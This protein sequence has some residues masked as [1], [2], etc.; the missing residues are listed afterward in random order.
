M[1]NAVKVLVGLLV[2]TVV[3]AGGVTWWKKQADE[4]YDGLMPKGDAS[5][6][7]L[8]TSMDGMRA[9]AEKKNP[10]MAKTDALKAYVAAESAKQ[11]DDMGARERA[12]SAANMFWG[13][14]YMNVRARADY[15]RQRGVDLTPFVTAFQAAHRVEHEKSQALFAAA[16]VNP[17]DEEAKVRDVIMGHVE[18]DMKDVAQGAQVPLEQTCDL[19][20]QNAEQ[21]AA[22]IQLP[23]HVKDALMS[24]P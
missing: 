12:F 21:L 4:P 24:A 22:F 16:R 19:F 11:F 7:E 9:E 17:Q 13:F 6:A 3:F 18:Q 10:S 2:A 15:C 1:G 5:A 14:H 8:K 20:N 23:P